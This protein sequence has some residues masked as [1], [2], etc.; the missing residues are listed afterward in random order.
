MANVGNVT[1]GIDVK[2]KVS[3][4]TARTCLAILNSFLDSCPGTYLHEFKTRECLG[5][6]VHQYSLE[7]QSSI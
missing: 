2:M 4:E 6:D 3:Q 7:I 5:Y 1:V